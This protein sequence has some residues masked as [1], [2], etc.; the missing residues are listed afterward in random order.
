MSD[1]TKYP[2][3]Q[4]PADDASR[5][6]LSEAEF[7]EVQGWFVKAARN[8]RGIGRCPWPRRMSQIQITELID[9]WGAEDWGPESN[10]SWGA[11]K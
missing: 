5:G 6:G 9:G 10:D 4:A 7:R 8:V 11:S 1:A 2:K 3:Y